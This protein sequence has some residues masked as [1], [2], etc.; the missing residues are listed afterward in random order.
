[1][2]TLK[3]LIRKSLMKLKYCIRYIFRKIMWKI[4]HL[5]FASLLVTAFL[6]PCT[7]K[8]DIFTTAVDGTTTGGCEAP[9]NPTEPA[10]SMETPT[11]PTEP[12][13]STETPEEPAEELT[14]PEYLVQIA[15]D[16]RIILL[17]IL[18]TFCMS[19]MRAWRSHVTKGV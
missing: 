12:T 14:D 9:T 4:L 3:K 2:K 11:E 6:V 7:V 10:E 5:F 8:A 17:V 15:G 18:L 16:V 13:E 1:M 19:C